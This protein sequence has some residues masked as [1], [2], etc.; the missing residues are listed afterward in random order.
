[1][2]LPW[3]P[4]HLQGAASGWAAHRAREQDPE[5]QHAFDAVAAA[6][7]DREVMFTGAPVFMYLFRFLGFS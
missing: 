3:A 5:L 2:H 7:E 4:L 1:M 6:R